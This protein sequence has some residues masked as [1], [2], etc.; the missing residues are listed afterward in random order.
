MSAK[1]IFQR[2]IH[3]SKE[4]NGIIIRKNKVIYF[5]VL[6]SIDFSIWTPSTMFSKFVDF[7]WWVS[8]LSVGILK[9]INVGG[10]LVKIFTTKKIHRTMKIFD[11][12]LFSDILRVIG[13]IILWITLKFVQDS[14]YGNRNR[15]LRKFNQLL[16]LSINAKIGNFKSVTQWLPEDLLM[17]YIRR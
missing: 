5:F 9:I 14:G 16:T 12:L 10:E 15:C 4:K 1:A 11:F 7:K 2:E 8:F 6:F 17:N 3:F 13:K